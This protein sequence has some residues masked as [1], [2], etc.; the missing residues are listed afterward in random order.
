MAIVTSASALIGNTPMLELAAIQK[1]KGLHARVLA[2]LEFLNPAG[3]VKDRV[4]LSMVEDAEKRGLLKEGSV[5]I[6]FPL[7]S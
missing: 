4:A 1:A 5:I 2:K 6:G 3:S 7:I